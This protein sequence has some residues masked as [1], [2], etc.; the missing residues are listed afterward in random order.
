M[1]DINQAQKEFWNGAAS[2]GWVAGQESLDRSLSAVTDVLIEKAA[3]QPGERVLDIGCGTG[4]T[5]LIAAEKTGP[6]GAVLGAD[7]SAP[8]LERA[9]DRAA[10]EGLGN[11][12][13]RVADAQTDA[14]LDQTDVV[15]SRFG[16]MFFE[17]PAAAF[18][19]IRNYMAPQG[20]L[21]FACWQSPK[22]NGWV[23]LPVSIA[24]KYVEPEGPRDPHAPGPF[25]FADDQR[26]GS[27]LE[28]AGWK[29]V[30]I[31]PVGFGMPFGQSV[32]E[33]SRLLMERGPVKAMTA[34]LPEETVEKIRA[35]IAASLEPNE[36]GI[37]LD[38][39]IW[40]VQAQVG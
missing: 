30:A 22:V 25:A 13:F 12:A 14:L 5:S 9:R 6:D 17:D 27:I 19:N 21:C 39:A 1:S 23:R 24:R 2:Q 28:Q 10:A 15:I 37:A 38:A 4:Q 8:M 3:I 34:D 16:V 18:A 31:S 36:S 35:E 40:I 7:I 11:V 32:D 29:D 33:A 26:V 20:R